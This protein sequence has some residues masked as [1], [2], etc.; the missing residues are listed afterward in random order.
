MVQS[1]LMQVIYDFF[2]LHNSVCTE[3]NLFGWGLIYFWY[4]FAT[5]NQISWILVSICTPNLRI[6]L[7]PSQC[8]Y[9]FWPDVAFDGKLPPALWYTA[10]MLFSF[11]LKISRWH[12]DNW[13]WGSAWFQT[14]LD[15]SLRLKATDWKLTLS[16]STVIYIL[17]YKSSCVN[18]CHLL[19]PQMFYNWPQSKC[20]FAYPSLCALIYFMC[21]S[22]G[23]Q[24]V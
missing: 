10:L 20:M 12:W 17:M 4:L 24:I 1:P 16:T 3:A 11:I 21:N 13:M 23:G 15:L 18:S 5:L 9:I 22:L 8:C 14:L 2:L 7:D 6:V 19:C